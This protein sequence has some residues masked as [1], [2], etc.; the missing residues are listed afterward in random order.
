MTQKET[1]KSTTDPSNLRLIHITYTM[2]KAA[3]QEPKFP[4]DHEVPDDPFWNTFDLD[5]DVSVIFFSTYSEAEIEQM[6]L[7]ASLTNQEK[8]QFLRDTFNNTLIQEGD[9]ATPTSSD[10]GG[11]L[12]WRALKAAI[13]AMDYEMGDLDAAETN[14]I[15]QLKYLRP[16]PDG[17][18]NKSILWSLMGIQN[19]RGRYAECEAT[20]HE[21][22]DWIKTV[23]LCGPNSPQALGAMRTLVICVGRQGRYAEAQEWVKRC[24]AVIDAM[25]KTD[26]SKYVGDEKAALVRE[27]ERQEKW[28][29]E[30]SA[31]I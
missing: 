28:R 7:D 5:H 27:V 24:E 12:R 14:V 18:M 19:A 29:L 30:R 22:L 23:P 15:E 17:K 1:K 3:R 11:Y 25:A 13:V 9:F 21:A 31:K 20:A 4:W 2:A 8:L 6:T 26:F 10:Y 16:E